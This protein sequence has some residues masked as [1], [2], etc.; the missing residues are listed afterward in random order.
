VK[1]HLKVP[2][3][4]SAEAR[5]AFASYLVRCPAA[6]SVIGCIDIHDELVV[7]EMSG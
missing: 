6:Q 7:E 5:E 1:C 2:V 4:K 3:G